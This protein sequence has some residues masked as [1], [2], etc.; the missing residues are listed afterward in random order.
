MMEVVEADCLTNQV[1]FVKTPHQF[2]NCI[3]D[4]V[5]VMIGVEAAAGTDLLV[6]EDGW[7][8]LPDGFRIMFLNCKM[9]NVTFAWTNSDGARTFKKADYRG[10]YNP[11]RVTVYE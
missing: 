11:D 3:V 6:H 7:G 2:V 10:E 8:E 9:S 1:I 5:Y 4:N